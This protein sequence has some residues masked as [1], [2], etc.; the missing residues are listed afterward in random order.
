MESRLGY[1]SLFYIFI[2]EIYSVMK[3][4][5]SVFS[6]NRFWSDCVASLCAN[7]FFELSF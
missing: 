4:L 1:E 7:V 5:C 3:I 6:M 2:S